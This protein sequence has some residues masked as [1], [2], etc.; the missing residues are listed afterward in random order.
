MTNWADQFGKKTTIGS[1]NKKIKK[2]NI[3]PTSPKNMDKI[4]S[5]LFNPKETQKQI[6]KRIKKDI[7][8]LL[9]N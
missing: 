6:N 1:L 7:S 8:K 9:N 3:T 4:L 2:M 5:Q